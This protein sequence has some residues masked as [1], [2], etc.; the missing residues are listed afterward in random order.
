MQIHG[1][2]LNTERLNGNKLFL[3][4]FKNFSTTSS[5]TSIKMHIVHAL[6]SILTILIIF[7]I[8]AVIAI[9]FNIINKKEGLAAI[10]DLNVKTAKIEKEYNANISNIS[11]EY[12]LSSG[13]VEAKE[14]NY[15]SRKDAAASLSFLYTTKRSG[16]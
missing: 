3:H 8:L 13:Y 12:A 7:Y 15:V 6:L 16:Q 9:I 5:K 1:A 10:N 11:K 14:D 4:T 2:Q